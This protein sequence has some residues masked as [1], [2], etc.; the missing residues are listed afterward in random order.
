MNKIISYFSYIFTGIVA[1]LLIILLANYCDFLPQKYETVGVYLQA[2]IYGVGY[3]VIIF[4]FLKQKE[5][6]FF[7]NEYPFKSKLIKFKF[8]KKKNEIFIKRKENALKRKNESK[9]NRPNLPR[10][11]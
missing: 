10:K 2:A 7:Y 11:A 9:I 1:G 6:W 4:G 3:G 8:F 5:E